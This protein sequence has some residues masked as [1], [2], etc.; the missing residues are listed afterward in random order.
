MRTCWVTCV[1]FLLL[2]TTAAAAVTPPLPLLEASG[3]ASG[4]LVAV[5]ALCGVHGGGYAVVINATTGSLQLLSGPAP[6]AMAAPSVLAGLVGA[7]AALAVDVVPGA[8]ADDLVVA[9]RSGAIVVLDFSPACRDA[10]SAPRVAATLVGVH[11]AAL[12]PVPPRG[13]GSPS[14][15]TLTR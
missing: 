13:G 1:C 3:A 11:A 9:L 5:G 2:S 10:A 12:A 4:S 15:T 6:H 14:C 7:V 8:R